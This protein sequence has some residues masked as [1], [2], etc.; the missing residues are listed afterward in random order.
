MPL[1]ITNNQKT[2]N[3]ALYSTSKDGEYTEGSI[4][5]DPVLLGIYG[6]GS[7]GVGFTYDNADPKGLPKGKIALWLGDDSV[8]VSEKDA[9]A[10]AKGIID[11][12][13]RNK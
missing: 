7:Q 12:I 1:N 13:K 5:K 10:F 6:P 4:V 2:T 3:S 9:L 11:L 8:V